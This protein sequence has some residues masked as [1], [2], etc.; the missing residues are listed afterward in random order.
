MKKLPKNQH[1]IKLYEIYESPTQII[2]I[3]EYMAG[4]DIYQKIKEK[5]EMSETYI[6]YVFC[7]I[8]KGL[9]F[10]HINDVVHRDIKPDN[11]L[12]SDS[13]QFPDVRI[14]DF[15]LADYYKNKSLKLKCGT[16]GY[17]AP[18]VFEG[19][20]YE[21]KVDIFSLGIVLYMM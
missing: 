20:V 10:L 1:I 4:G 17:M 2:L 5:N 19:Q 15:S 12:L 16:P 8:L 9:R 18:E 11:I 6:C 21:E 3:F 14:A 7:Q 13:S